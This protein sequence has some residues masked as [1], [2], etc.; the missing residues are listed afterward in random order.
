MSGLRCRIRLRVSPGAARSQLVGRREDVWKV[1]VKAPPER[2]RA[3]EAVTE[4]LAELLGVDRR[5]VTLVAGFT[6]KD[7]VVEVDG[8]SA[9][10]A[11][12]ILAEK[13]AT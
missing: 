5:R 2:G 7:K 6:S 8:L 13:G 9:E 10:D 4:L 12:R 1:R 3:N 11:E